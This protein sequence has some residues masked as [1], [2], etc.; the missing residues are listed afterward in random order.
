MCEI[1]VRNKYFV[2]KCETNLFRICNSYM[3]NEFNYTIIKVFLGQ[4]FDLY[5]FLKQFIVIIINK[6]S[7]T[8]CV[9]QYNVLAQYFLSKR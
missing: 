2:N 8:M 5:L 4:Y 3:L 7:L 1:S 6:K 9:V